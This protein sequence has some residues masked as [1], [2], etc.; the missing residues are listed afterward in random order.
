[1][2]VIPSV[3]AGTVVLSDSEAVSLIS[4]APAGGSV[5]LSGLTG[6][7]LSA[8]VVAQLLSRNDIDVT[9]T[10]MI[11]G[12]LYQI[13]IPAGANLANLVGADGSI[14]FSALGQTFGIEPA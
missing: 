3:A 11:N 1:M 12:V 4:A 7:G 2:P 5:T 6:A 13:V 10:F 8:S 9:F 14:S